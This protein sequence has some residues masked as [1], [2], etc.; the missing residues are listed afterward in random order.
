[1]TDSSTFCC[2]SDIANHH[3][4]FWRPLTAI[5]HGDNDG[6]P[7]TERDATWHPIADTPMHPEYPCAYC[8]A[9]ATMCAVSEAIF[10]TSEIPEVAMRS[11][12]APGV[13]HR[14]T[15]LRTFV[16]EVSEARIWAG[17][18][19]GSPPVSA[20][21]WGT[22]SAPM[23]RDVDAAPCGGDALTTTAVRPAERGSAELPYS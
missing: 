20:P 9:A 23:S 5:R 8:V 3:H 6:N 22:R 12:T 13:T 2:L 11:R 10:V 18:T 19:I 21:T 15:N 7:A 4:G 17:S 1:M 16:T 14:F